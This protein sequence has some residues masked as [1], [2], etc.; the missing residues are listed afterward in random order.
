MRS[1]S[2]HRVL[3]YI[4]PRQ[5]PVSAFFHI[6]LPA[7]LAD[8][9]VVLPDHRE[10]PSILPLCRNP[11]GTPHPQPRLAEILRLSK[12][13]VFAVSRAVS[14]RLAVKKGGTAG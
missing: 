6:N 2:V 14:G 7:K 3:P 4:L 11:P 13:A 12:R 5:L 10:K 8:S 9:A 1:V